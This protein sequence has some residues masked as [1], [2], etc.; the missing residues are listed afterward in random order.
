ML[1]MNLHYRHMLKTGYSLGELC[2]YVSSF[3]PSM[4]YILLTIRL[5]DKVF[6]PPVPAYRRPV[7]DLGSLSS[8]CVYCASNVMLMM[9]VKERYP[10]MM[11]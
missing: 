5:Y 9:R 1:E 11:Q 10:C 8:I 2:L 4:S 3:L 7:L 6:K